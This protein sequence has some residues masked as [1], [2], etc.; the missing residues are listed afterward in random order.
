MKRFTGIER[1]EKSRENFRLFGEG[2]IERRTLRG[3]K[4]KEEKDNF[5]LY[6]MKP[7]KHELN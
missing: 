4:R 7:K 3:S 5:I 6:V 1:K 2:E